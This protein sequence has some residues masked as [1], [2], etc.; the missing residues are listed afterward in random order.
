MGWM[1]TANELD[2]YLRKG[3][4]AYCVQHVSDIIR[5][6]AKTPFHQ[7]LDLTFTN[8]PQAV[9]N[10]FDRF[11]T[12][13]G[14]GEPPLAAIYTETNG[15]YINPDRWY[16]GLFGYWEYGGGGENFNWLAD[17]TETYPVDITL[18][19]ME[20]LQKRYKAHLAKS[21]KLERDPNASRDYNLREVIEY[22]NLLVVLRFQELIQRSAALMIS[23][24]VPILAT[25]HDYDFIYQVSPNQKA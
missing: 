20:S 13:E 8:D 21:R 7:V 5:S 17:Y 4:L 6:K 19:G 18:T 10:H 9:A 15:F 22:C 24:P 1:D 3:D 23:V 2:I 12:D 25:S 14:R 16:F 11:Y